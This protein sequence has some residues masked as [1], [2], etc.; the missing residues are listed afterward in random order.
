[1]TLGTKNWL[2]F[3]LLL[4]LLT[5]S[6]TIYVIH[7]K[8]PQFSDPKTCEEYFAIP[9]ETRDEYRVKLKPMYMKC[10]AGDGRI[11]GTDSKINIDY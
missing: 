10:V 9:L 8:F 7:L 11:E 5:G 2:A 6:V 3:A 1:M 4:A